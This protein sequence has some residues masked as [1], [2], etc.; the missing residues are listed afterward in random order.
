MTSGFRTIV[1]PVTDPAPARALFARLFGAP[2]TDDPATSDSAS[3]TRRAPG[4]CSPAVMSVGED[5][6]HP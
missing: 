5:G 4:L 2:H 1:H 3:R 6:S